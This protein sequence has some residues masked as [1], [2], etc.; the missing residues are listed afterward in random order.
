MRKGK[1]KLLESV[2]LMEGTRSRLKEHEGT[3]EVHGA[4]MIH[5]T[6]KQKS[7]SITHLGT[8]GGYVNSLT[9]KEA[10]KIAKS[11]KDY[12]CWQVKDFDELERVCLSPEWKEKLEQAITE[13]V[14]E[15]LPQH[16][17]RSDGD[18]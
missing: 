2:E 11:V 6:T 5:K 4:L 3:F 7:Y 12:A 17:L 14:E 9:L 10:R 15:P 18:S 8:G 1:F 16:Q 13:A